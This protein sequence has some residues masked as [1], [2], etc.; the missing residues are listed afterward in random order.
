MR[1]YLRR[2]QSR[3]RKTNIQGKHRHK[4]SGVEYSAPLRLPKKSKDFSDSLKKCRYFPAA[5]RR[6]SPRCAR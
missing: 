1:N 3:A 5:A 6:K 2:R 4:K